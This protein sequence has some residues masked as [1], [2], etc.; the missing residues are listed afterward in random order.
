MAPRFAD[1]SVIRRVDGE[2]ALLLGGGRALLMQLAHPAV[3]QGVAEHS[4]FEHDPLKRLFGTLEAT[5][6]IVFGDD[7]EVERMA[8]RVRGLHRRVNGPG[9][10]A[11]DP[12]LLCWVNATLVDTSVRVY[13][14]LVRPLPPA[15]KDAYVDQSRRVAEVLGC[16]LDA[17]PADWAG[18]RHYVDD[19][20]AGLR[21]SD[22]ARRVADSILHPT[23]LPTIT[24]PGVALSRW[25][26]VGTLPPTLR[27]QYGLTWDPRHDRLLRGATLARPVHRL[28]PRPVRHLPK[29][30]FLR[31][32]RRARVGARHGVPR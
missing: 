25:L 15:D 5:Y 8:L 21:V 22:T 19:T 17:Q 26:T 13:E 18:F 14:A 11:E 29:T 20:V 16:P 9:Y 30:V 23:A 12:A 10:D 3:A 32:A 2:G 28:L 4:D 24:R 7:A 6:T 31:R 27:D 1:G